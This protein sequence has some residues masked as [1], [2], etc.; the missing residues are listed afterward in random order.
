MGCYGGT[1]FW[2]PCQYVTF[3]KLI[4]L[5]PLGGIISTDFI[6]V[7]LKD[8]SIPQFI[9]NIPMNKQETTTCNATFLKRIP[10]VPTP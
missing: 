4:F 10:N 8:S 7:F 9:V 5:P 6:V 1:I 3:F 2:A